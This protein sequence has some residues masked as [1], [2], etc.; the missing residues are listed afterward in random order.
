MRASMRDGQRAEDFEELAED[1]EN[2]G[3]GSGPGEYGTKRRVEEHFAVTVSDVQR[4]M[5]PGATE[6]TLSYQVGEG[7]SE[8]FASER[9]KLERV[10]AGFGGT[11]IYLCC[12]DPRCG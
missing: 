2:L 9:V 8:N 12:P 4:K 10:A 6:V 11:R 5:P 1:F 7:A 3:V